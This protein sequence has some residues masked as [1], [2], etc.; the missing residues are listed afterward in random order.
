MHGKRAFLFEAWRKFQVW[1]LKSGAKQV[2]R[3]TLTEL[4]GGALTQQGS[5]TG[6]A[7][8]REHDNR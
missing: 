2:Q 8:A 7:G 6:E 4:L 1:G 3:A 5:L